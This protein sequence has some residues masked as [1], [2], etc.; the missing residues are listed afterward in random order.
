MNAHFLYLARDVDESIP[1]YCAFDTEHLQVQQ[2]TLAVTVIEL[3]L[4]HTNNDH[5]QR[6]AVTTHS[7]NKVKHD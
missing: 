1:R 5:T 7:A 2:R 3:I 6:G 4:C